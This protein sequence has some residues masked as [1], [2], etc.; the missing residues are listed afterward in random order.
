MAMKVLG[1]ESPKD[2]FLQAS[3]IL[4][5]AVKHTL[6]PKGSN[7]A[8]CTNSSGY[9][10]I[11]NDGKSIVQDLT[12]DSPVV[13]PALELLKQSCFE[14]NRIAGDGTTST[15]IMTNEI[16]K[17]TYEHLEKDNINPVIL[18]NILEKAKSEIIDFID[19]HKTEIT[20]DQ[21]EDVATVA[22]GSRKYAKIISDAYKFVGKDGTVSY[23][24]EDRSDVILDCQDGITLDKV[25]LPIVN[26]PEAKEFY[27]AYACFIYD[28]VDRFADMIDLLN[29]T[30]DYKGKKVFIFYNELSWEAGSNI[31]A[32]I[33]SGNIDVIPIRLGGY[34]IQTR[35]VMEQLALYTNC[36][37]IDGANVKL[38]TI[39]DYGTVFGN[40]KRA[41]VSN[42]RVILQTDN[43]IIKN[44]DWLLSLP[45]NSCIIRIGGENKVEQEETYRRIEDAVSSLGTA[46]KDG[47]TIGGGLT[48]LNAFESIRDDKDYD[49]LIGTGEVIYRTIVYNTRG[50]TD[51]PEDYI[52][53]L[54]GKDDTADWVNLDN[55]VFDSVVVT[56]EVIRNSFSLVGQIITTNRLIHEMIR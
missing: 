21:Y 12:S 38:S 2:V 18:R 28:K 31:Y 15:I 45:T 9:Y 1:D 50:I 30:T 37:L 39:K 16:L 56:K 13:A 44:K 54:P 5:D 8:V 51:I 6:G 23:I 33:G 7:T 19:E 17:R 34:G 26:M 48:Y 29:K 46:I 10:Q 20:E 41:M 3:Q 24:K 36:S 40:I 52:G 22:L 42:D 27:D 53:L 47:I 55:T 14:T 25:T 4:T 11:I 49:F 32:N 43:K 35:D